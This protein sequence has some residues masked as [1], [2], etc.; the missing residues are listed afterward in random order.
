MKIGS[1]FTG[2]GA[3]D[4][5]AL[6]LFP[7][8]SVA[9]ECENDPAACKLLAHHHPQLINLGDITQVDWSEVEPVDILTGGFPCQDISSA[10]HRKGLSGARSGL[11]ANMYTAIRILRP[12]IVLVEN[13]R[14]LLHAPA[15]RSLEPGNGDLGDGSARPVDRALGAVLGDLA[16]IGFD[17]GWC[18]LSASEVGCCHR[19]ERIFLLATNTKSDGLERLHDGTVG[20]TPC[21]SGLW[22]PYGGAGGSAEQLALLPT[23]RA[24]DG[25]GGPDPLSRDKNRDDVETRVLRIATTHGGWAEFEPAVRRQ[26][27]LTRPVP[28]PLE[29]SAKGT[30]RLAPEFQAW[31][32]MLPDGYLAEAGLSRAERLRLAGNSVVVPQA[33]AGFAYIAREILT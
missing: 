33:V 27:A 29:L 2:T 19:R 32:M 25:D 16:G 12:R 17:A 14:G 5:A 15:N 9:W 30:P 28:I 21:E 7:D 20:R 1:L 31:M 11:W 26:E 22:Q 6:H 18:L 3:L 4:Q 13:V 8:A 23:P 24:S 10:G